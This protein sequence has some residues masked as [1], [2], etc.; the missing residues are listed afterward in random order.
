MVTLH[1][2]PPGILCTTFWRAVQRRTSCAP[3]PDTATWLMPVSSSRNFVS[4][5]FHLLQLDLFPLF[6]EIDLAIEE[7]RRL[8]FER[9]Q[10]LCLP[11][12]CSVAPDFHDQDRY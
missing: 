10:I 4:S 1:L 9:S 12:V 5:P 11:S 6:P 7:S 3:P 2:S 8:N